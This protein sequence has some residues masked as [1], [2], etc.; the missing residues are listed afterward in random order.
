MTLEERIIPC[1]QG[2]D[3][4]FDLHIGRAT[5]SSVHKVMAFGVRDKKELQPRIDYKAQKVSELLTRLALQDNYV[6]RDMERG[7]ELEPFARAAYEM[8]TGFDVDEVGFVLHP[9]MPD[10]CGASPD[11][12]ML[13]QR[14]GLEIKCPR[15][16]THIKYLLGEAVPSDYEPQIALNMRCADLQ[17]MDFVSYCPEMPAHLKLFVWRLQRDEK[18]LAEIDAHIAQ[19]N[20]EVDEMIARL[21]AL[22]PPGPLHAQLKA[23]LNDMEWGITDSDIRAVDPAW[24][25]SAA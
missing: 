21:N 11:G 19:F 23:S 17:W 24:K 8:R 5:A 2:G 13:R 22:V 3:E 7:T 20:T 4:W 18:R 6:S 15:A 10:R 14:G 9:E 25:G 16:S 12:L 1:K